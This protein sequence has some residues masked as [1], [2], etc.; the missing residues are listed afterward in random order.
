MKART[1]PSQALLGQPHQVSLKKVDEVGGIDRYV[2]GTRGWAIIEF[3][4]N[5]TWTFLTY[6]S[7]RGA[8]TALDRVK[9][10]FPRAEVYDKEAQPN[11]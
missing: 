6:K 10:S 9:R 5:G 4:S 8:N 1:I 3:R 11:V 7:T 2:V